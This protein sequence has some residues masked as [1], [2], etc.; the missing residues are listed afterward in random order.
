LAVLDSLE[1]DPRD[2]RVPYFT[3][4]FT[5]SGEIVARWKNAPRTDP[6]WM[7]GRYYLTQDGLVDEIVREGT[8]VSMYYI[9]PDTGKRT[10]YVSQTIELVDPVYVGLWS[11]SFWPGAYTVGYFTDVEL[12]RLPVRSS[13]ENWESYK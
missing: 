12:T 11:S 6:A 9:D 10:L 5:I 1:P 8:T 3:A 4:W 2:V 13:A 7:P